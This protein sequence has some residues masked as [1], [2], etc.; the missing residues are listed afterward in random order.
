[1]FA[2]ILL[3]EVL[4]LTGVPLHERLATVAIAAVIV[5][6]LMQW[7]WIASGSRGLFAGSFGRR[8]INYTMNALL[9]IDVVTAGV[10]GFMISKVVAPSPS[11][12]PTEYIKWHSV[13]DV[14]SHLLL[15]LVALH[16]ALNLDRITSRLRTMRTARNLTN[17]R[18]IA[19]TAASTRRTQPRLRRFAVTTAALLLAAVVVTGAVYAIQ[20]V[21][22]PPEVFVID[23]D[24]NTVRVASPP[25]AVNELHD[26]QRPVNLSRG[27]PLL[28]VRGAVVAVTIIVGRKLFR[29]HL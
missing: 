14:S 23:R 5:H 4:R 24:G 17:D 25:A 16:L 15:F 11:R 29:L 10:S 13:H 27:L 3:L 28:A 19:E 1:M 22:P 18:A 21:M 2:A 7:R 26:D 12:K 8:Q 20:S 9:F 6:I